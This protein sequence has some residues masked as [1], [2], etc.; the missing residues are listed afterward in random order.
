M[1]TGWHHSLSPCH[2]V[3]EAGSGTLRD[4]MAMEGEAGRSKEKL[5]GNKKKETE[6]QK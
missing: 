2:M 1:M 3:R 5:M 6:T 4:P